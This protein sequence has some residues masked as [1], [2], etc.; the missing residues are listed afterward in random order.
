MFELEHVSVELRRFMGRWIYQIRWARAD[1]RPTPRWSHSGLIHLTASFDSLQDV[2]E[3]LAED[4]YNAAP[5]IGNADNLG[6]LP[7][8]PSGGSQT[9]PPWPNDDHD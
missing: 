6:K 2:L 1:D 3:A 8:P 4:L 7:A 5:V 9:L